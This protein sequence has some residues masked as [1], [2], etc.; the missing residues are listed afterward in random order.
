MKQ[1]FR[2]SWTPRNAGELAGQLVCLRSA[3]RLSG[4]AQDRVEQRKCALAANSVDRTFSLGSAD[5]LGAR[6][7]STTIMHERATV[8]PA[9][10]PSV[11]R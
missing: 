5:R 1:T 10:C 7:L 2:Q 6:N 4:S 8:A 3:S 11:A 9:H